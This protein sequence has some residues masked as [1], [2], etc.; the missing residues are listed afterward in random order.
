MEVTLFEHAHYQG[1]RQ[2]VRPGRYN[3]GDLLI[4]NDTLSSLTVPPGMEVTLFEHANFAGAS[5]TVRHD[6]PL[7]DPAFNDRTSSLEVRAGRLFL[8]LYVRGSAF[9]ST[10]GNETYLLVDGAPRDLPKG[11]GLNTVVLRPNGE[12]KA[13]ATHDV[14]ARPPVWNEWAAWVTANAADGDLVATATY[15]AASNAPRGGAAEA[16]LNPIG[17]R[18]AFG[19]L[20]GPDWRAARSSYALLFTRGLGLCAEASAPYGGRNAHLR[21]RMNRVLLRGSAFDSFEGNETYL[22][23][24]GEDGGLGTARGLNTAILAPDGRV[25]AKASHD[26]YGARAAWHEWATWVHSTAAKG[27]LVAVGSYDAINDAP[28][29]GPAGGLLRSI[30]ATRA[31]DAT[32]GTDWREVRSPYALLFVHGSPCC[33][34]ASEPHQGRNARLSFM[35]LAPE[36][37][38]AMARPVLRFQGQGQY[39]SAELDVSEA[40]HTVSL[41][42]KTTNPECGLFSADAGD[43]GA[44]GNDRHVYLQNGHLCARLWSNETI[45]TQ[46]RN[47]ADNRWHRVTHVFGG[48]IGG[49]RLYVDGELA[50]RGSK[51]A[52][53][54]AAQDGINIGFS[55]DAA[56]PY[57]AGELAEVSLWSIARS[58]RD[59]AAWREGVQGNEQGLLACWSFAHRN[60]NDDGSAAVLLDRSPKRLAATV[61]GQPAWGTTSDFPGQFVSALA[62]AEARGVR[63]Q[64]ETLAKLGATLGTGYRSAP[65]E[66]LPAQPLAKLIADGAVPHFALMQRL[67][68]AVRDGQL[69]LSPALLGEFGHV[70]KVVGD[71]LNPFVT[72]RDPKIEFV[73][74]SPG[75]VGA[76]GMEVVQDPTAPGRLATPEDHAL[77]V[78]GTLALFGQDAV[79]LKYADFFH[80]KGKPHCSFKFLFAQPM[81]IGTML[82]GVPLLQGLQISGP[83]VVLATASTLYDPSLDSGINVGFNFFGNLKVAE[84][85]D[86]IIRFLGG[87]LK[88]REMAVHAAVDLSEAVPQYV[89]EGSVQREVTLLDGAGFKLRFT[90]SDVSLTVKGRPPEPAVA[91]SHD[92]VVT[93]KSPGR[94]T[95]L[96]FTGG[97]KVEMESI[98]G[99]FTMN[100]TGRSPEGALSGEV[101]N[102][103]EWK[104]PFGIPG[105]IIRQ[106]AAQLGFT[107]QKPYLDNVGLHGNL[108]IG[109][110]DGTI[111]VLVDVNDPDQFVLAGATARI[112]VLQLLSA[113]STVTFATYQALPA[114]TKR[115]L[116]KVVNVHLEDVKVH[117]VPTATSIGGVHFRDEGVTVQGRLIAWGWRASLFVNVDSF[118]GITAR[119]EMDPVHLAGVLDITGAGQEPSPQ[120]RLRLAPQPNPELFITAKVTLLKL[121]TE[122]RLEATEAGLRFAFHAPWGRL[123]T[124]RLNCVYQDLNLEAA[125][126]ILFNLNLTL[127]TPLGEIP[128]VDVALDAATSIKA[129]Q[130]HG[131]AASLAGK[132]ALAGREVAL[133]PLHLAIAPNDFAGLYHAVVKQITDNG[134]TLVRSVFGTLDAWADAVARGVIRYGGEIAHVARNVY[135]ASEAAALAAYARLGRTASDIAR[136]LQAAYGTSADS[137]AKLLK[138]ANYSV[139]DVARAL[140]DT[141]RLGTSAAGQL[142]KRVG[143][144]AAEAGDGLRSV[145]ALSASGLAATLRGAGYG[146]QEVA[147]VVRAGFNLSADGLAAALKGAGYA[148]REVADGV[149]TACNL[150]AQG[151]ATALKGAGYAVDETRDAVQ[152]VFNLSSG[153]LNDALKGAGYAAKEVEKVAENVVNTVGSGVTKAA[154]KAGDEAK[155]TT[156]KIKKI[157]KF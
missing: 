57:F 50:A 125:G 156:K 45:R 83:V 8:D 100:G 116:N 26:V 112:T 85:P 124:A 56:S 84:S 147:G 18:K 70:G 5:R 139:R 105:V 138:Q 35:V 4:G 117:I 22:L 93:L 88:V 121:A 141:Y 49:Q 48:H 82:P 134:T 76:P 104:H 11:R 114:A 38:G 91:M 142:L 31:F 23:V 153:A 19:F 96:V 53:D 118:D 66:K 55:N 135:G 120:L 51:A 149:R 150:S 99:S 65:P 107:Y 41:W 137:M 77:K 43:R 143:Y 64:A 29:D 75:M 74:G 80:Y 30:G 14:Y 52:S 155:K 110:V 108:K 109:D 140:E 89:L 60:G 2:T 54:F 20:E 59:L 25:K 68:A 37:A 115:V 42:F 95:H 145:Y 47:Y 130:A 71:L 86:A 128:L 1:R 131:F 87:L 123:L 101:Q 78:S 67:L 154:D 24:N 16:L 102:T 119:G 113:M 144:S 90:R 40:E 133:P 79:E 46:G 126:T 148:T 98:T 39:L 111:S 36:T 73:K 152:G 7:L 106:M 44:R 3:L 63:E 21:A 146:V 129:G 61:H 136:G 72:L 122:L 27:D 33:Q 157:F 92:L 28:L 58:E 10:E 62:P 94:T 34:E 32:R 81:G 13:S 12:L 6:L 9:D 127:S 132:F 17:T 15:D 69:T 151:V 97:V 103:S